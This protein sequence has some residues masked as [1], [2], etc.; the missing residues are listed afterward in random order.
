MNSCQGEG[1]ETWEYF[2]KSL[3]VEAQKDFPREKADIIDEA[4][5]ELNGAR[6]TVPSRRVLEVLQHSVQ[7]VHTI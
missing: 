5:A 1:K 7:N 4:W 2:N 6:S 3:V